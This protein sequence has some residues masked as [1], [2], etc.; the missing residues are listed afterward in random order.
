MKNAVIRSTLNQRERDE[1]LNIERYC[2]EH[3]APEHLKKQLEKLP[4]KLGDKVTFTHT[5]FYGDDP[6]EDCEKPH[7][8]DVIDLGDTYPG[9]MVDVEIGGEHVYGWLLDFDI[10]LVEK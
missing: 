6:T 9:Y 3:K 8:V 2:E 1:L 10:E 4:F 7:T 5:G